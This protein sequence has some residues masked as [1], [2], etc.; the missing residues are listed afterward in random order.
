MVDPTRMAMSPSLSRIGR[1]PNI[2]VSSSSTRS[3]RC[4]WLPGTVATTSYSNT[5]LAAGTTYSYRVRAAD[6]TGNLS[7]YSGVA[8]A[9]TATVT[10]TFIDVAP[11]WA[12]MHRPAVP[13]A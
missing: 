11:T 7:A 9:V 12:V 6:A 2:S 3:F 8:T 4:S 13:Q 5:G 10:D 1:C